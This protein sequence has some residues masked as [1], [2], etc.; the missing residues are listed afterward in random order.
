LAEAETAGHGASRT[1]GGIAAA[2]LTLAAV[3]GDGN[4]P[5]PPSLPAPIPASAEDIQRAVQKERGNVVLVNVW[6][7]WCEPCRREFPELL[8]VRRE[9]TARGFALILVSADFADQLPQVRQ[10]L[11]Q[12]GVGFR[13]YLK[14]Q[15]DQTFI[16]TLD[17]RWSGALPASFLYD[18]NGTL[19]DFW[20]G[21]ASY[22]T[23]AAR[24]G[25]LL[26]RVPQSGAERGTN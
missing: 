6:A 15:D 23:I 24:V 20:E 11:A 13:T 2:L 3:A 8:R 18:R 10:F 14:E 1:A 17:T 5:A 25:V 21:G 16:D 19:R 26:G 9:L 22:E 7:T 12:Q 4:G